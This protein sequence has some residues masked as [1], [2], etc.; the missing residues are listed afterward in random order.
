M[1]I[2]ILGDVTQ[3]IN[4]H[5]STTKQETVSS[6]SR[7]AKCIQT[8]CPQCQND[9]SPIRTRHQRQFLLLL[10]FE[11]QLHTALNK[12]RHFKGIARLEKETS[13][14]WTQPALWRDTLM[15]GYSTS[16]QYVKS[17]YTIPRSLCFC[18]KECTTPHCS[19]RG[20]QG[21]HDLSASCIA[22]S[23]VTGQH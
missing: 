16:T 22:T 8:L 18:N 4:L 5:M 11:A 23:T 20:A 12:V 17:G 9:N 14:R 13:M 10:P 3:I 6:Q 2:D 19:K 1:E 21:T 15:V 7:L